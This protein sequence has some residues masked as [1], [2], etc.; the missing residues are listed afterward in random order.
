M[1]RKIK[2]NKVNGKYT[3]GFIYATSIN[4]N[5]HDLS[6]EFIFIGSKIITY[7]MHLVKKE[8]FIKLYE[9]IVKG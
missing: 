8:Y 4:Y 6:P 7:E 3:H 1:K 9:K 2:P 5:L